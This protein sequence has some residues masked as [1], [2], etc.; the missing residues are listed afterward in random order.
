MSTQRQR[1]AIAKVKKTIEKG[2]VVNMGKIMQEVGYSKATSTQPQVLTE[3]KS[4]IETFKNVD[5]GLQLKQ[6]E[7]LG[8]TRLNTDKDNALKAKDM[9]FKLGD[10]YP[11]GETKII[12]IFN[13]IDAISDKEP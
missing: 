3:S 10:K 9:L 13:K 12:G 4:W 2:G 11:K 6:V 1:Q 8:D 5:W 7:D